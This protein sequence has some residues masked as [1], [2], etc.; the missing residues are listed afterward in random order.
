MEAI[1][2]HRAPGLCRITVQMLTFITA[3]FSLQYRMSATGRLGRLIDSRPS[4]LR[5]SNWVGI[6]PIPDSVLFS[7][8]VLADD[9]LEVSGKIQEGQHHFL[10]EGI[11]LDA[12][13]SW[14]EFKGWEIA[15]SPQLVW[16]FLLRA[17]CG[18][19]YS[20]YPGFAHPAYWTLVMLGYCSELGR[21]WRSRLQF[22]S[23]YE[24]AE[25]QLSPGH[26]H[27]TVPED[28]HKQV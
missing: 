27:L 20:L 2:V 8:T 5:C 9:F 6:E 17:K 1:G 11:F 14:A 18:H 26:F 23:L 19:V 10:R 4:S 22:R 24:Y 13:N 15:G 25:L 3:L 12:G 21:F 16:L 7:S 28:P